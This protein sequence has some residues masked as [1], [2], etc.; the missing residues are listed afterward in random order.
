MARI[1]CYIKTCKNEASYGYKWEQSGKKHSIE[2][3]IYCHYQMLGKM[4]EQLMIEKMADKVYS[5]KI[6]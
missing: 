3:C 1:K 5:R 2:L 4:L 6:K